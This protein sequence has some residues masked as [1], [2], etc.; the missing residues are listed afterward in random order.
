MEDLVVARVTIKVRVWDRGSNK[1][2]ALTSLPGR[3]IRVSA[4]VPPSRATYIRVPT[5][6]I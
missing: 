3:N 2:L 4:M 1:A 6:A 5:S